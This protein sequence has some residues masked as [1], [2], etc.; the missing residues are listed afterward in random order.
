MASLRWRD[1]IPAESRS[2][3]VR[4][5]FRMRS[6]ARAERPSRVTAVSSKL[7]AL[8]R[9]R[10]ILPDQ[11]GRH[12]RVGVD[13]LFGGESFELPLSRAH[14]ALANRRRILHRGAS[15]RN[16]LYFTAGTSI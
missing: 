11:F 10:A 3:I 4:A 2:A 8:G 6:C 15:P 1:A 13:V 5:T 7:L 9:N 12:L 14:H 16:S